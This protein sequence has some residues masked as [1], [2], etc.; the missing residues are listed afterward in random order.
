LIWLAYEETI[1]MSQ[2][3]DY[4]RADADVVRKKFRRRVVIFVIATVV[5]TVIGVDWGLPENW[6]VGS[7]SRYSG[8]AIETREGWIIVCGP[9][10]KTNPEM[11]RA[12]SSKHY[13]NDNIGL[14]LSTHNRKLQ[15]KW[16]FL[17]RYRTLFLL[18]MI[19][20]IITLI[21]M[22]RTWKRRKVLSAEC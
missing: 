17:V 22:I 9:I 3:I 11:N 4:A 14:G 2:P 19:P 18:A 10:R 20:W 5:V 13:R 6:S 12:L 16:F 1:K 7:A 8:I 15:H 21:R